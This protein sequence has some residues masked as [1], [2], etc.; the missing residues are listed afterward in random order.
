MA[1]LQTRLKTF[2][3]FHV[4]LLV[5]TIGFIWNFEFRIYDVNISNFCFV[6]IDNLAHS[7]SFLTQRN[8]GEFIFEIFLCSESVLFYR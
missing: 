4:S 8:E 7:G 5:L 3:S 2:L 1:R 6:T